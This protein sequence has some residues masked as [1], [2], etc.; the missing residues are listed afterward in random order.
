VLRRVVLIDVDGVGAM[1]NPRI[2]EASVE[3]MVVWD[4]CLSFL[5]IVCQVLRHRWIEVRFETMEGETQ[6]LRAE[7][8]LAEL[9]QHEIDHLDGI[10]TVDRVVDPRTF[11]TRE[12]FEKRYRADSPY[13]RQEG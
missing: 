2:T 8:D 4:A 13:G 1:V 10:L 12:E 9:L 7:G 5:S 11:C 6:E 3:R